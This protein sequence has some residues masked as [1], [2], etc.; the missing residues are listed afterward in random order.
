MK[1]RYS[2]LLGLFALSM[3]CVFPHLF[4]QTTN[5]F[6]S[7]VLDRLNALEQQANY[8]KP[9]NDHFMVAGLTTFGFIASKSTNTLGGVSSISK[10]NSLADADHYEFSPMFLWRHGKKFLLE[11]EPSFSN[12]GLGVNWADVSYFAAP[13]VIIRAGYLV[14]PFGTYAKREAAG[15]IDKLATDPM[16][17][18]DMTPTDYGVEIE[19]GLPLGSMK[20]NYDVALSNGSQLLGNGTL[21]SGNIVD[22]NNNKTITARIG[23]L[24]FSNSSLEIGVSGMFGKVG[25]LG[26]PY[27]NATGNMYAFD[28]NYVKTFSPVLV[29]IK[30]QYD[31]QNI[32]NENY[33][34]P[35][36]S[37]QSYSFNNHTTAGFVQCSIRPTE[38]NNFLKNFEIAGRYTSYNLPGNSTFGADQHAVT[39]GLDYWL[40]WR[41]VVK[42]TYETYTGNS[43]ASKLLSAY[44][45]TTNTNTFYLQFS[46]QL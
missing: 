38:A 7:T 26:S 12:N 8:Q 32:S 2:K 6:D 34:N 10:T 9:G 43:T 16:G 17:I 45:G 46:I 24:P 19:G 13:N 22:N 21:T 37:T 1:N 31:I 27:Q 33:L 44:N 39:V 29:N 42:A 15:W 41:T 3:G 20:L 11:F 40:T 30:A 18:A 23:W 14:L 28:L 5:G 36:D 25:D 4:A 35:N